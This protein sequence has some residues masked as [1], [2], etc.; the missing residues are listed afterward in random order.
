MDEHKTWKDVKAYRAWLTALLKDETLQD[1]ATASSRKPYS[2][3]IRTVAICIAD[4]GSNGYGCFKSAE[5]IAKENFGCAGKTIESY[6]TQLVEL[7]WFRVTGRNG[8]DNRRSLVLDIAI[9]EGKSVKPQ[10]ALPQAGGRAESTQRRAAGN[11]ASSG[12]E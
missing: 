4:A 9:P 11:S 12:T 8:G 3:D 6:R 1:I 7:G 5:T 2:L 10:R